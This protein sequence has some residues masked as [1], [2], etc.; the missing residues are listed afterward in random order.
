MAF[1]ICGKRAV[2]EALVSKRP[3]NYKVLLLAKTR[4]QD[5][6]IEKILAL[7]NKKSIRLQ[8]SDSDQ[9]DRY[10]PGF[11]NHQGVV[12]ILAEPPRLTELEVVLERTAKST[13]SIIVALDSL[14]DHQNI[15]AIIRTAVVFGAD[16]IMA[17][18]DRSAPLVNAV[19]WRIAQGGAEHIDLVEITNLARSLEQVKEA[20][21]WVVGATSALSAQA[22][23]HV[24]DWPDKVV[25]VCGSESTGLRRL[26]VQTC[27]LLVRIPQQKV[28]DLESLNVSHATAVV[29]WEAY[30]HHYPT[31]AAISP[32]TT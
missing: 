22:I 24:S 13:K 4:T 6:D 30:K 3:H 15:G 9:L 29:L 10:A 23:H 21:F 25:V 20:G 11:F 14:T 31:L 12:L 8:H 32:K 17:P 18:R 5:S 28:G 16:A 2:L 26:V 7:A 19:L 27:D 1:P